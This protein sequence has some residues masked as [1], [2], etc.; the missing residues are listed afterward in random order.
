MHLSRNNWN[1]DVW[2]TR[3]LRGTSIFIAV[4][5]K[6]T[7]WGTYHWVRHVCSRVP[8]LV[9]GRTVRG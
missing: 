8:S 2:P 6:M 4:E 1:I 9:A 5:E 7:S 3:W